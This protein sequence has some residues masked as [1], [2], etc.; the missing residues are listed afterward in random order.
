MPP[1]QQ[2]TAPIFSSDRIDR[3]VERL[4]PTV[5]LLHQAH[6]ANH[7]LASAIQ[8]AHVQAAKS[9]PILRP[10]HGRGYAVGEVSRRGS[11]TGGSSAGDPPR[12][13]GGSLEE[14]GS[15]LG[16]LP[17]AAA[18]GAAHGLAV[19]AAGY[20]AH[21]ISAGTLLPGGP[22]GVGFP[23]VAAE[24][25]AQGS[26]SL[27]QPLQSKSTSLQEASWQ[28]YPQQQRELS[29]QPADFGNVQVLAPSG[30]GSMPLQ[31]SQTSIRALLASQSLS[32]RNNSGG[33]DAR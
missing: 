6:A 23:A 1:P 21:L 25:A 30:G 4:E 24:P 18:S 13:A 17:A 11:S 27:A 22:G 3:T 14:L 26:S 9:C 33:A 20:P 28:Q 15:A 5:P 8:E 7:L 10:A 29:L 32:K 16:R 19:S 31:P 2:Q 12:Q